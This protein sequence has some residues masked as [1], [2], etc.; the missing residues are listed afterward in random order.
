MG[1]P[2]RR[3]RIGISPGPT[4]SMGYRTVFVTRSPSPSAEASVSQRIEARSTPTFIGHFSWQSASHDSTA[5]ASGSACK[6]SRKLITDKAC[7]FGRRLRHLQN[8]NKPNSPSATGA[9]DGRPEIDTGPNCFQPSPPPISARPSR[10]LA[11]P[12][13]QR[14]KELA[15]PTSIPLACRPTWPAT[16]PPRPAAPKLLNLT[17][18]LPPAHANSQ[19][20][21]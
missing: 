3:H 16:H 11:T 8:F 9:K 14:R 15:S 10:S 19:C 7:L 17:F 5:E 18:P 13:A 12:L 2:F 4:F 6:I 20:A 21:R 1:K